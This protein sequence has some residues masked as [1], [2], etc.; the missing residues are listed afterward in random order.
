MHLVLSLKS[1]GQGG[2]KDEQEG[3]TGEQGH[4]LSCEAGLD[5]TQISPCFPALG[6]AGHCRRSWNPSLSQMR[7]SLR[8]R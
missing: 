3:G 4:A 2:R 8:I 7:H 6:V 5:S 1:A